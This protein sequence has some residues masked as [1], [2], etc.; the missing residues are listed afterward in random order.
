MTRH[1]QPSWP[2]RPRELVWLLVSPAIWAAH[3]LLAYGVAAVWCEKRAPADGSLGAA[4]LAIWIFTVAALAAIALTG[5][6]AWQRQRDAGRASQTGHAR[7]NRRRFLGHACLLLSG[8]SAIAVIFGALAF[9]L[10]GTC[11]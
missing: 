11:R 5:T 3:F 8:L 10:V 1:A 6:F 2:E 7:A 4:G 9:V